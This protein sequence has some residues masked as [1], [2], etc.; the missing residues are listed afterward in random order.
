MSSLTSDSFECT[1]R[2]NPSAPALKKVLQHERQRFGDAKTAN[3]EKNITS[4]DDGDSDVIWDIEELSDSKRVWPAFGTDVS[5]ETVAEE[6]GGA[7]DC[8]FH[9]LSVGF[10]RAS[11]FSKNEEL[12][13]KYSRGAKGMI[14][15][16]TDFSKT[17]TYDNAVH[18][19][20]SLVDGAL[21]DKCNVRWLQTL[22]GPLRDAKSAP[23]SNGKESDSH[24]ALQ[25]CLQK[26]IR[27]PGTYFQG[28]DLLL[29]H[30]VSCAES[31]QVEYQGAK[32]FADIDAW[33]SKSLPDIG[34]LVMIEAIPGICELIGGPDKR[35]YIVLVNYG[36]MH[37]RLGYIRTKE[38]K[39]NDPD[40]P[41]CCVVERDVALNVLES[42]YAARRALRV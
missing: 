20:E 30:Y 8:F 5:F 15:V 24:R 1:S 33:T 17:V 26:I 18:L 19:A 7:G 28:T 29:R 37:W 21:S 38:D 12:R 9:C 40:A 3:D 32:L 31:R 34:F 2:T 16:R 13:R 22:R 42:S 35:F 27:T 41:Y 23:K 39:I 11:E 6:C 10:Y 14:A 25:S 36:N 4:L